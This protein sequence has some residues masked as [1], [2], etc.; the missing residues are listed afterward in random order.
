MAEDKK[1]VIIY[2]D[3]IKK[4]EELTDDEAG[5]LIKHFFRYVNDQNPEPP[6]RIT[7]LL[8]I[9]IENSLKRDLK[10]WE[11]R[12]ERSRENGLKGGRPPKEENLEKPKETQQVILKPGKPDSVS[13][14]V[15][16][17]DSV[18]E[19]DINK[20]FKTDAEAP[21]IDYDKFIVKFNSFAGRSF[22]LTEKVKKALNA[23]LKDYSKN[24]IISAIEKAHKEDFHI[25]NNFKHLTPEFILRPDKLEKFLNQKINGS[26]KIK[27]VVGSGNTATGRDGFGKL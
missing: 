1:A 2:A 15:I 25:N 4:F 27:S 8:F 17:S 23:R 21:A 22:R 6:D 10:K 18:K 5:R 3:W 9:D 12:A 26:Q 7:K 20:E 14:S 16:V 19:T 11:E 13:V 24:E